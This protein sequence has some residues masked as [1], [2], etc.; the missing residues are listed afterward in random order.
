[1]HRLEYYIYQCAL[2]VITIMALWQLLNL[3]TGCTVTHCGEGLHCGVS[4]VL[5]VR[6]VSDA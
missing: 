3:G 5:K 1:M 2:P 4:R 6:A